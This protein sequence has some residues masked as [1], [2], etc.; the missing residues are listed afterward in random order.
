MLESETNHN[1]ML[2]SEGAKKTPITIMS[3]VESVKS[4]AIFGQSL[5]PCEYRT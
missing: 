4:A 3:A 1:L 5:A 2:Y